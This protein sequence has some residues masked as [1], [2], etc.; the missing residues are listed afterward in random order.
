MAK[1][2]MFVC[3]GILALVVPVLGNQPVQITTDPGI[4]VWPSWSP[5]GTQIAFYSTRSGNVDIW[6]I[7]APKPIAVEDESWGAIKMRYK[8]AGP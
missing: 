2:F 8:A 3:L 6:V 5:D 1:R 4:D 7:P